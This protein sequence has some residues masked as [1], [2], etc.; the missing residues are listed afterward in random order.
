MAQVLP[1]LIQQPAISEEPEINKNN[2]GTSIENNT[3]QDVYVDMNINGLT[4]N[5]LQ[6][7]ETYAKNITDGKSIYTRF[8]EE[9]N[10]GLARG[11]R[12]HAEATIITGRSSSLAEKSESGD[13][14]HKSQTELNL[15][16]EDDVRKLAIKKKVWYANTNNALTAQYGEY[17]NKGLEATVW[18]D[19]KNHLV[20]KARDLSQY[21]N[22]QTALDSITLHNTYFPETAQK[23]IGFGKNGNGD[24]QIIFE[25]PYIHKFTNDTTFLE[26]HN[27]AKLYGFDWDNQDADENNNYQNDTTYLHDLHEDNLVRTPDGH[28]AAIDTNMGFNTEKN[29][30]AVG[31]E[32]Q[33]KNTSRN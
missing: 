10:K 19:E 18:F 7:I 31:N 29:I 4:K 14:Q 22:L 13:V 33:Y 26:R 6:K 32:I 2:L 27:F 25:Q 17:I 23:V 28:L 30:R 12:L 9:E 15:Q 8:T 1:Y 24:F 5:N 16:Q 20:V 3:L 11:D 21:S